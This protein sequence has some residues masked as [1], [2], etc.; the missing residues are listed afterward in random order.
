[1]EDWLLPRIDLERCTG[2]GL[3][4]THCPGDVVEMTR[5]RPVIRRPQACTYCGKCEELCPPAAIALQYEIVLPN[6][7]KLT[8]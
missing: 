5:A 8:D 6:H 2:C 4:A 3:C 7:T 1:M